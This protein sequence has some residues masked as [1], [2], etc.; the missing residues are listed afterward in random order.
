MSTVL[1]HGSGGH[2]NRGVEGLWPTRIIG[3]VLYGYGALP[4]PRAWDS[5]GYPVYRANPRPRAVSYSMQVYD[6]AH[7]HV[8]LFH[9][10][11]CYRLRINDTVGIRMLFPA[12]SFCAYGT[13]ST[14][15]RIRSSL[16]KVSTS[17]I[18]VH[19]YLWAV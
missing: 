8:Y 10:F 12:C 15:C 16:G 4:N 1:H 18:S 19:D 6:T 5:S 14:Y 17:D 3:S 13:D 2:L 9:R 7:I 11:Y